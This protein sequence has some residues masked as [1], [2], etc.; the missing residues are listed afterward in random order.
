VKVPRTPA[1]IETLDRLSRQRE[2]SLA[3]SVR[4]ERAISQ[5]RACERRARKRR[6]ASVKTC[7]L[8]NATNCVDF[9]E[10]PVGDTASLGA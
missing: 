2:L 10:Q 1:E 6:L 9:P 4:L 8:G 7:P 5:Q 3:E